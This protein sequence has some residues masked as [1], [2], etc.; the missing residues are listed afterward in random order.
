MRIITAFVF[1]FFSLLVSSQTLEFDSSFT[2]GFI[3]GV[4]NNKTIQPNGKI[5]VTGGSLNFAGASNNK[6]LRLNSNGGLDNSFSTSG[7]DNGYI[8]S[9]ALDANLKLLVC[10]D[11]TSFA[12]FD[13]KYIVRL[14]SDGSVDTS[15]NANAIFLNNNIT[16]PIV[17][18]MK[19]DS[20]GKI[21]ACGNFRYRF[22][23][24]DRV[25]LVKLN[26]NGSIHTGY[27]VFWREDQFYDP[28]NKLFVLR[29]SSVLASSL[30]FQP[31]KH[32][33]NDGSLDVNFMTDEFSG[34][35][36][37]VIECND[38]GFLIAGFFVDY[39]DNSDFHSYLFMKLLHNGSV[40]SNFVRYDGFTNNSFDNEATSAV[41]LGDRI[42]VAGNF[43]GF[44]NINSKNII[45]FDPNG[46]VDAEYRNF[47]GFDGRVNSLSVVGNN[48]LVVAGSFTAF[49]NVHLS[50]AICRLYDPSLSVGEFSNNDLL[51]SKTNL[52]YNVRS[53]FLKIQKIEVFDMSGRILQFNSYD[54]YDVSI[55]KINSNQIL[56]IRIMLEGN[57]VRNIKILS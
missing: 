13:R 11:F 52:G 8:Y 10:G 19:I 7:P 9:V 14:N 27:N 49:K 23:G 54:E 40:D 12:G 24:I 33:L 46:V 18:D 37:G 26:D 5:I 57:V 17:R 51:V 1:C 16:F 53:S 31:L 47:S 39:D 55:D 42:Y 29:D 43:L 25:S 20:D 28:I 32:F 22:L 30:G 15:F 48:S 21:L 3:G 36:N 45:R 35:V 56:I 4:I 44:N 34:I 41:L 2:N 38:G 50:R 6:I